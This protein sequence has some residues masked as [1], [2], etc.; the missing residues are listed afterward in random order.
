MKQIKE[1]AIIDRWSVLIEGAEGKKEE[2]FKNTEQKLEK[3]EVPSLR[4]E[5]KTITPSIFKALFSN[6]KKRE[7]LL[8]T[9]EYLEGYLMYIGAK[10]YGKQLSVSWYLTAEP[11][12]IWSRISEMLPDIEFIQVAVSILVLPLILLERIF[13]K[14]KSVAPEEM[15]IF[16]LEELTAYITTVHHALI[17]ATKELSESVDFDFSKVD[18]KSKGFLNIS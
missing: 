9:N 7:F 16:D 2:V 8:A 4:T 10:D 15:D 6:K 11:V 18:Q 14:K 13:K 17:D 5:R 12:G 1:E 3:I